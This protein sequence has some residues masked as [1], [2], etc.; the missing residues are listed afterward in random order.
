MRS[1]KY[2]PLCGGYFLEPK[3][4]FVMGR[5]N[6][7]FRAPKRSVHLVREHRSAEKRQLQPS[8]ENLPLG[9]YLIH[10]AFDQSAKPLHP[11]IDRFGIWQ[12]EVQPYR[13]SAGAIGVE[14][15]TRHES[16]ADLLDRTG[17]QRRT[18]HMVRQRHPDEHAAL[19]LC[20]CDAFRHISCQGVQHV[21]APL[22]VMLARLFHLCI[23]MALRH[24]VNDHLVDGRAVQVGR[25]L[26][27]DQLADDRVC[28]A[29]PANTQT[30]RQGFREAAGIE[31]A[32]LVDMAF[33][34]D[35]QRQQ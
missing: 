3:R 32:C 20:P 16:H 6:G 14:G 18:I 13:V 35:I 25:L 17:E 33:A 28:C 24:V 31:D 1:S 26:D 4:K 11:C 12:R 8:M 15:R 5:E 29:D 23:E 10:F 22:P 19:R 21:I 7:G 2:L 27:Q 9:S 34:L 30:G